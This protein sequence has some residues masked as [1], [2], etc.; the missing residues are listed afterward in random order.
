VQNLDTWKR[1]LEGRF[2][3]TAWWWWRATCLN[4]WWFCRKCKKSL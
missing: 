2:G 4:Y 3:T 1:F